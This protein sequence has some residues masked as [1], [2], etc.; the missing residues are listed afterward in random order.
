MIR[1]WASQWLQRTQ[2]LA[3][4]CI[5]RPPRA[6]PWVVCVALETDPTCIQW[7]W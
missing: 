3:Y 6:P 4:L 7:R 1:E 2:N 5:T